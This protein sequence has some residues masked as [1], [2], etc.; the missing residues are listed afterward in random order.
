M[1]SAGASP[2][3]AGE[4]PLAQSPATA[5]MPRTWTRREWTVT[6]MAALIVARQPTASPARA[7]HL[8]SPTRESHTAIRPPSET[9]PAAW[10]TLVQRAVEAATAAGASYADARITRS[11]QHLYSFTG[12][13]GNYFAGDFETNGLGV[14]VL[15]DGTW[16]FAA[17]P[18]ITAESAVQ[19]ARKAVVQAKG[20]G[21][22]EATAVSLGSPPAARGHWTTPVR[23][24]PFSISIEEKLD[25]IEA[26][27][28]FSYRVG[29]PLDRLYSGLHCSRQERALATSDGTLCTQ[30]IY[31]TGGTMTYTTRQSGGRAGNLSAS[32]DLDGLRTSGRGW[33]LFDDANIWDQILSVNTRLREQL[34][35]QSATRPV[36]VGRYTLVCDGDTMAALAD[37][38]LGVATQL[39]RALG[40][41]ANASGTSYLDDPLGMLGTLQVTS[42][43]VTFTG[44]RSAPGQLATVKWD[45]E[46]VTPQETS[47]VTNGVLTDFQTTREQSAWLEPYYTRAKRPVASHGYAAAEHALKATMQHAPNFAVVPNAGAI[48][49]DRMIADIPNGILITKGTAS[50][51]MQ[52]RTGVLTGTMRQITNGRLRSLLAGGAVSFDTRDLW[53]KITLI[54]GA[55]TVGSL[56]ISQ[57]P[58]GT[59]WPIT[60]LRTKGQPAQVTSHTVTAPAAIITNQAI[61]DLTKK[62]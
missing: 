58:L 34:E 47:F 25:A 54:G 57:N 31:E 11:V 39:D 51:D 60:D 6:N 35:I 41:E 30:C 26:W 2:S 42:P 56:S 17:M 32:V 22:G 53:Q 5:S 55:P 59:M 9:I 23:I 12:S 19:M 38:T 15:V 16:G 44:N 10:E 1:S 45:D 14:R 13:R 36:T 20:N 61:V 48:T 40:Y 3:A 52:A 7:T 18:R 21:V 29:A 28:E 37:A 4:A 62:A 46:G 8:P 50:T 24:D 49:L 27:I 33:E 43:L